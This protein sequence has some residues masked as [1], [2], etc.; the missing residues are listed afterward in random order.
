MVDE[1]M[2]FTQ[3][4]IDC[5]DAERDWRARLCAD[6]LKRASPSGSMEPVKVCETRMVRRAGK[7]LQAEG[8]SLAGLVSLHAR[9]KSILIS[10]C[11]QTYREPGSTVPGT[12][13]GRHANVVQH[14]RDFASCGRCPGAC[15]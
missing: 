15:P 12:T 1:S 13:R 9:H 4:L 11:Q 6:I 7:T 8:L 3:A 2:E 14:G 10:H 5:A